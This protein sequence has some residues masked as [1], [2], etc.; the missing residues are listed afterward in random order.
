LNSKAPLREKIRRKVIDGILKRKKSI[1][2]TWRA[3]LGKTDSK[4]SRE[5]KG[6]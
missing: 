6:L 2:E 4:S 3:L 5:T 1:Q